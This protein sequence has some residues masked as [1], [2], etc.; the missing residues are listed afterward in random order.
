MLLRYDPAGARTR[1]YAYLPGRFLPAQ[2]ED[3]TGVYTVHGDR[4]QTPR[5]VTD[6]TQTVV[7]RAAYEAF[8]RA[9]PDEDPD[10]DGVPVRLNMRFA[11][12]YYDQETGLY[13]NVFRYYDPNT[14][15]Y[16][17]QDPIGQVGLICVRML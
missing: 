10:G 3:A 1:A 12:Q 13:Y 7:W 8:G 16:I 14:G 4:L 5:I 15:R 17:T 2:M 9:L 6:G 11:G